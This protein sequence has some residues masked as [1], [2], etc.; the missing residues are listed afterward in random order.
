MSADEAHFN[1]LHSRSRI[2]VEQAFGLWKNTFRI[3]KTELLHGD[4]TEMTMLIEAILVL[5]NWF[6]EFKS[7]M[8]IL[9]VPST[10]QEW[11]HVSGLD[12][13]PLHMMMTMGL[14]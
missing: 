1:L 5:H 10:Y 4:A 7:E 14:W 13:W 11:M 8:D 12:W 9:R 2:H 6:I 3:F